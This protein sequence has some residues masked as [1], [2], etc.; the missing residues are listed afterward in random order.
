MTIKP[1]YSERNIE[2]ITTIHELKHLYTTATKTTITTNLP[3]REE[4]ASY[5]RSTHLF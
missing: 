2:L 4:T 3:S 5:F 1:F